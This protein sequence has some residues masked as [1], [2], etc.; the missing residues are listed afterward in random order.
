MTTTT[1]VAAAV[2]TARLA[3]AVSGVRVADDLMSARV[4][5]RHITAETSRELQRQLAVAMYEEL[6]AGMAER[7]PGTV[8]FHLRDPRLEEQLAAAVPHRT[9]TRTAVVRAVPAEGDSRIL[10]EREGVRVWAPRADVRDD[11]P[12]ALGQRVSVTVTAVR[13]AL[14]PGFFLVD[15]SR[16]MAPGSGSGELLRVYVHLMDADAAVGAWGKMLGLLEEQGA[17]YRAK[18][19]SARSLYPRR[20]ALVVYLRQES[21]GLAHDLAGALRGLPGRGDDVSLFA[22]PLAPGVAAAREPADRRPGMR[23][24]SFGQ[25]R[26]GVLAQVLIEQR[27]TSGE[28]AEILLHRFTEAGISATD[29]ADNVDVPTDVSADMPK[30][31]PS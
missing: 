12:Y 25:H 7:E 17:D 16:A 4:G 26:A 5:D 14:S 19:L 8:P 10:L 1:P 28:L 27:K 30:N 6:H 22:R 29:P 31:T 23:G 21:W 24:L 20:D 15:G 18:V 11:G 2:L 9:T 3:E 13:P